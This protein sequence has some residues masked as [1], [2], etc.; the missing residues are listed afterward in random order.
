MAI[1]PDE[2]FAVHLDADY[3][4]KQD[5][6][7]RKA[8]LAMAEQIV[9]SQLPACITKNDTVCRAIYEQAVFLLRNHSAQTSGKVVSSQTIGELS[10]SFTLINSN[11]R[12]NIAPNAQLFIDMARRAMPRTIKVCRG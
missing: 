2:Y 4:N 3:W 1:T 10:Q 7:K 12:A 5:E 9:M 11:G 6:A 8:A